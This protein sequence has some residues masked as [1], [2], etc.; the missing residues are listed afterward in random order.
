MTAYTEWCTQNGEKALTSKALAGR[1]RER[2]YEPT[3]GT[4]GVRMWRGLG[5][6]AIDRGP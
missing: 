2:G 1:L 5:L 6:H 3:Q 4:H